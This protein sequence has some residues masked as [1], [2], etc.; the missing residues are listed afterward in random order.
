M[1]LEHFC[2]DNLNLAKCRLH[3][4]VFFSPTLADTSR[5][6]V[7]LSLS[8]L[9]FPLFKLY[10]INFIITFLKAYRYLREEVKTFQG[11]PIKVNR[12][13]WFFGGVCVYVLFFVGLTVCS[14]INLSCPI[15]ATNQS[16]DPAVGFEM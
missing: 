2:S 4:R 3:M 16:F 15:S 7:R 13:L 10:L 11:K 12:A 6:I 9:K 14:N 1:L 5:I 8:K